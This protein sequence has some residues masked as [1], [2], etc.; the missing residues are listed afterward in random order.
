MKEKLA[1]KRRSVRV[2]FCLL[3]YEN[4]TVYG[5]R[6]CKFEENKAY[7]YKRRFKRW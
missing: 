6:S 7:A 3:M 2:D 4:C 1:L 5:C